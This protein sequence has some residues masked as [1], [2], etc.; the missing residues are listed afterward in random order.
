[1]GLCVPTI[2]LGE[3]CPPAGYYVMYSENQGGGPFD[4]EEEAVTFLRQF[5]CGRYAAP[6]FM[7][8]HVVVSDGTML[9][10][11]KR[12]GKPLDGGLVRASYPREKP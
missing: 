1:M 11:V 5:V 9:D 7:Q 8:Y 3:T 12:D 4:K 10:L 6:E 2:T